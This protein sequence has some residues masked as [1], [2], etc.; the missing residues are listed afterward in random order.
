MQCYVCDTV[1]TRENESEEH[2]LLNA[3]GG[4]L[5]SK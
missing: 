5:K 2:I 1:L 3:I 4:K